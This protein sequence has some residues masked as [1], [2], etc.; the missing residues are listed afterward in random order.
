[1]GGG[2]FA[3][4]IFK[5]LTILKTATMK[6]LFYLLIATFTLYTISSCENSSQQEQVEQEQ[7]QG[8]EQEKEHLTNTVQL[9]PGCNFIVYNGEDLGFKYWC[10]FATT[11]KIVIT[12]RNDNVLQEKSFQL[13]TLPSGEWEPGYMAF[14]LTIDVGDY[15]G[16]ATFKMTYEDLQMEGAPNNVTTMVAEMEI[17]EREAVTLNDLKVTRIYEEIAH[18]SVVVGNADMLAITVTPAADYVTQSVDEVFENGSKYDM[19]EYGMDMGVGYENPKTFVDNIN[20]LIPD[21]EYIL[22]VAAKNGFSETTQFISFRTKA[23]EAPMP[24]VDFKALSVVT[25]TE[26]SVTL[27]AEIA[28]TKQLSYHI[29]EGDACNCD[30]EFYMA[31][32]QLVWHENESS[33]SFE[34]PITVTFDI[35]NLQPSTTYFID[36]LAGSTYTSQKRSI[37]ITT[38]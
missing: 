34:R 17:V 15:L 23:P 21:T 33:S 16:N 3:E 19:A 37:V 38:K 12:D 13:K 9:Y 5:R 10:E 27:A 11:A 2:I 25:T 20:K 36:V 35:K 32:L 4:K 6:K 29:C 24:N 7:E 8:Q 22:Q 26:N 18:F 14:Q 31:S 30:F 28:N 1:M